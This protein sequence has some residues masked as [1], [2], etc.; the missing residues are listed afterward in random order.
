M[1]MHISKWIFFYRIKSPFFL[2]QYMKKVLRYL[3]SIQNTLTVKYY[4]FCYRLILDSRFGLIL[5]VLIR[6]FGK[7][8]TSIII[9]RLIL[10]KCNFKCY[11]YSDWLE[12]FRLLAHRL[13]DFWLL[14]VQCLPVFLQLIDIILSYVRDVINTLPR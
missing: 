2:V 3:A 12:V 6:W 11:T 4:F 7:K 1:N 14:N 13:I 9:V 10:K 8:K 5:V